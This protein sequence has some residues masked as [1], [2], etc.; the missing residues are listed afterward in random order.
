MYVTGF[1][2][3]EALAVTVAFGLAAYFLKTVSPGGLAGGI[4]VG[5]SIYWCG[6]WPAFTVLGA[7][8]VTASVLTRI[9][10]ARK[11]E[12]GAEQAEGGRRGAR[13]AAANCAVGLVLAAAMK[14]T[15]AGTLLAAAFVA[16]FATAAADTAGSEAG[17]VFGRTAVL[18]TSLK[19]VPPGT[20][21]AISLE[22]TL[23]SALAAVVIS[24]VGLAV[25]LLSTVALAAAA[26]IS[27]F[28]AAL[29]ESV[30]GSFPRLEK[31]VGNE[32]MNVF[33]TALGALLCLFLAAILR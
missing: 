7:F 2:L 29:V 32:W 21:G 33:N 25:G 27:A 8:F 22:G 1:P 17:P 4:V 15:G 28:L 23:A 31:A 19:R 24:L 12:L 11:A 14:A 9:G 26:S 13:H 3:A 6:G 18:P 30:L 10:Y 20:P 16:S 5:T